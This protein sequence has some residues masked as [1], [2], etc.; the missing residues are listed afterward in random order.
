MDCWSVKSLEGDHKGK[1]IAHVD[2]IIVAN[3]TFKVSEAGRQRVFKEK[4]KNVHAGVV[5]EI[6]AMTVLK[7]RHIIHDMVKMWELP[8]WALYENTDSDNYFVEKYPEFYFTKTLF[9]GSGFG[10]EVSYNPYKGNKFY[11]KATGD[12]IDH[13]RGYVSLND[14]GKV[15]LNPAA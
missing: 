9:H 15:W 10:Y 2:N 7:E 13:T 4:R 8:V 5:G 12:T 14:K 6:E 11:M 1:V 3:P